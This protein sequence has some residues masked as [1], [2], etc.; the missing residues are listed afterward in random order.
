M[1]DADATASPLILDDTDAIDSI[2]SKIVR[3][4]KSISL[5]S[6]L[7]CM[8]CFDTLIM[9]CSRIIITIVNGRMTL[10]NEAIVMDAVLYS[11]Y[12][13]IQHFLFGMIKD[14]GT[15]EIF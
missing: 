12:C 8:C 9:I 15:S 6:L 13:Y 7:S 2:V 5:A 11:R 4:C 10:S 1:D 14:R 3:S